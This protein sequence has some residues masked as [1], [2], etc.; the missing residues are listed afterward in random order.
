[1]HR[2]YPPARATALKSDLDYGSVDAKGRV[3]R[4]WV[5]PRWPAPSRPRRQTITDR[6]RN[7]R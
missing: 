6:Y 7:S 5:R 2:S 1:M 3:R 4:W